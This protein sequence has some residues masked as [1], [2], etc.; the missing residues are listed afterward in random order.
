MFY[1]ATIIDVTK[2][3]EEEPLI[4]LVGESRPV[5]VEM[6]N[7]ELLLKKLDEMRAELAELQ[8]QPTAA[9]PK[10]ETKKEE[11]VKDNTPKNK[12]RVKAD[13]ARKYVRQ[14]VLKTWGSVPQ[15]QADIAAILQ[16]AMKDDV[17][18]SE[19]D[20]FDFLEFSRDHFESLRT[21]KQHVTYLFCYYRGLKNDGK[22]SGFVGRGFLKQI[23]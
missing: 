10:V 8:S 17:E 14:G 3:S 9:A 21:S 2:K 1:E 5:E 12:R 19:S 23:N 16:V 18:Y 22:H 6:T 13:P 11:V 7:E 15:Q 4:Q 20:V